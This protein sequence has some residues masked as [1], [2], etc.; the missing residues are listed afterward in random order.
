MET[1]ISQIFIVASVAG[2]ALAILWI[3][4]YALAAIWS[5]VWAWIDDT[6]TPT[7]NPLIN[8]VMSQLGWTYQDGDY[9]FERKYIRGN[10]K[11]DGELGFFGPLLILLC[12]PIL[13]ALAIKLYAATLTAFTLYLL[14]RLARFARRHKKL[15]DKHVKDPAAHK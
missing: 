11:S 4:L 15:F 2:V 13:L 12:G 10:K 8:K 6:K 9:N 3:F 5:R 14:A 1:E 7:Y